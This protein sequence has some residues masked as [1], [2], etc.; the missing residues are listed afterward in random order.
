VHWARTRAWRSFLYVDVELSPEFR[1]DHT[2]YLDRL[3]AL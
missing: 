3:L 1:E 2:S